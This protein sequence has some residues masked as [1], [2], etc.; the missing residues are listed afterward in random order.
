MKWTELN[1]LQVII[2]NWLVTELNN[3]LF[4]VFFY[5]VSVFPLNAVPT[6]VP[7]LKRSIVLRPPDMGTEL[8]NVCSMMIN[9]LLFFQKQNLRIVSSRTWYGSWVG[10]SVFSIMYLYITCLHTKTRAALS[11][12][13]DLWDSTQPRLCK[14]ICLYPPGEPSVHHLQTVI[15]T[16]TTTTLRWITNITQSRSARSYVTP[17]GM[18]LGLCLNIPCSH[19]IDIASYQLPRSRCGFQ[20]PNTNYNWTW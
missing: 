13:P 10:K 2:I 12:P 8:G 17:F 11:S 18:V 20:S 6:L 1:P 16:T 15:N 19:V 5:F 7:G 3:L 4:W 9:L 14:D